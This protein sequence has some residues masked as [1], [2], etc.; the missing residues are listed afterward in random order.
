MALLLLVIGIVGYNS[1]NKEELDIPTVDEVKSNGYPVN[2]DGLTY[3]PDVGEWTDMD[4][5]PD[6]ILAENDNGESGYV[7]AED[8]D[9]GED[10]IQDTIEKTKTQSETQIPMYL[11]DG[12]TVIGQFTYGN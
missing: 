8:L 11:Q 4:K 3:G 1:I 7:K 6:L 12:K 10:N 5:M 9:D 2:E